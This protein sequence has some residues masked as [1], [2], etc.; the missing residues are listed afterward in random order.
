[1]AKVLLPAVL[2]GL[3]PGTPRQLVLD[4][5]TV[6]EVIAALDR[7]APGMSDRLLASGPA[8]REHI[9]VFV[10][11]AQADLETP[12]GPASLVHVITAVSGG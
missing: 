7:Q 2:V 6:R 9:R 12:V 1:M 4:A 10:D 8:I 3:F 11:S 5:V